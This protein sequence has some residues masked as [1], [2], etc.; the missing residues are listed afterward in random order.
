[1]TTKNPKK[2]IQDESAVPAKKPYT[3]PEIHSESL[4]AFGALC[5]GT[6]TAGRK[7]STGAPNFCNATKLLS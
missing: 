6:V 2:E 7:A 3:K 5:N 4:M 1:M